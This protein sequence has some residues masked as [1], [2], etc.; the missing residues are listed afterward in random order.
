MTAALDTLAP[1]KT[2]T[3]RRGKR[4]S[5][6]LN[7]AAVDAKRTRRQLERRWKRTGVESD[8]VT[9]MIAMS[10]CKRRHQRSRSCFYTQQ[11]IEVAGHHRATWRL[12][13]ELLHSDDHPPSTS[14]RDAAKLF[15]G[16]CH[17]FKDKLEKIADTVA[18][19]LSNAAGYHRQA[20]K[21]QE[22]RLLDELAPVTVDEVV[23]L[24]RSLPSK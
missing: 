3:K 5:R 7:D 17:F 6:W 13:K 8:R 22:P 11:L 19:R 4:N 20:S 14:P 12:A 18:S 24:M 21:R 1:L 9:Y 16:F 23:Q 15:D 2:R 10:R